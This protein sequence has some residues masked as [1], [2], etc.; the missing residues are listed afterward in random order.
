MKMRPVK[1]AVAV[2]LI[3]GMS[4][5][6]LLAQ[7]GATLYKPCAACHTIGKGKII[8]PDL[9][10][11]T[12]RRSNEWLVSFI[13]SSNKMIKAGDL[14]AKALL[15]EYNNV[16]MPDNALT[17]EQVNLI[18]NYIDAGQASAE[19]VDP[20][21]VALQ[22]RIDSLLKAN[23]RQ[24]ILTGE[25]LFTGERRLVN[26]GASCISCHNATHDGKGV[27]GLLAKD[28][29][30][31]YSRL[32]GF[33]GLKGIIALPPF[34][35]MSTTYKHSPVTDEESAY[36]QLFLKSTDSQNL[37]EPPVRK[38]VF[39]RN[40]IIAGLLLAAGIAILWFRR[41]RRSVNHEIIKRQE[42]ISR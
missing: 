24:D 11:I 9:K 18:L 17:A 40:G 32:G 20:R 4:R 35:S 29:T 19:V 14:V 23:S 31:A 5:P 10:G 13:Q 1:L 26:G 42:R 8:G 15:A 38:M 39:F 25:A 37:I 12:K 27:G 30:K 21:Q 7:D 16:P 6:G 3:A 22:R 28:L 34:P 36:L 41:K 2:I 33:P